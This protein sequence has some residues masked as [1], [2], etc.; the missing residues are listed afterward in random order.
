[1]HSNNNKRHRERF[2]R[3]YFYRTLSVLSRTPSRG[4]QKK[5]NGS[6]SQTL[7]SEEMQAVVIHGIV[8]KPNNVLNSIQL[9]SIQFSLPRLD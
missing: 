2:S 4:S 6:L 7:L 3:T 9:D 1:M 5:K 8:I